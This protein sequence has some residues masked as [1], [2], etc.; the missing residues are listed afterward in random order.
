MEEKDMTATDIMMSIDEVVESDV[1]I[2]HIA[3]TSDGADSARVGTDPDGDKADP[4]SRF[5]GDLPTDGAGE[6]VSEGGDVPAPDFW[7]DFDAAATVDSADTPDPVSRF[8]GETEPLT[9]GEAPSVPDPVTE[10]EREVVTVREEKVAVE[11]ITVTDSTPAPVSTS[12]PATG[13]VPVSETA[14]APAPVAAS[15]PETEGVPVTEAAPAPAPEAIA[16]P[17]SESPTAAPAPAPEA[18]ATPASESPTAKRDDGYVI[19][20]TP[21]SSEK[22]ILYIGG[23]TAC[24]IAV[25]VDPVPAPTAT[26]A[27]TV[28]YSA[29]AGAAASAVGAGTYSGDG[30]PAP[31]STP[32][33]GGAP[34]RRPTFGGMRAADPADGPYTAHTKADRHAVT[35][36]ERVDSLV[37]TVKR[38][39]IPSADMPLATGAT[40]EIEESHELLHHATEGERTPYVM[41][42]RG[43]YYNVTP[44]YPDP[45]DEARPTKKELK[46]R[47]KQAKA[48]EER[49]LLEFE[50]LSKK[51][52]K[53]TARTREEREIEEME[54][55]TEAHR[56]AKRDDE[57]GVGTREISGA[58]VTTA[59]AAAAAISPTEKTA[60][61]EV[62]PTPVF[63]KSELAKT[64]KRQCKN[65]LALVE[66]RMRDEIR[67]LEMDTRTGDISF[68]AKIESGR[69]KRARGKRRGELMSAKERLKA[70]KKFE[71][72]DNNR[73]Y[74]LVLTDMDRVR[75]PRKT[76]RDEMRALR[77]RL[78]ELLR[79]RD[80]LNIELV[81]LYS[82]SSGGKGGLADGRYNAEMKGRKRAFK[83][84][85][86]AYRKY[87]NMQISLADKEK[88]YPLMDERTELYGDLARIAYMLGKERARGAAK[89]QLKRERRG[90]KR[91]LK[92]NRRAIENYEK[93]AL[94][95]ASSRRE[96]KRAGIIGWVVLGIVAV[97][98]VLAVV[99]WADIYE[100]FNTT[101]LP[102]LQE[103]FSMIMQAV[104]SGGGASTPEA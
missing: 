101:A 89:R 26:P 92:E 6:S 54:S 42:Q 86:P 32:V 24:E 63:K 2:S 96:Q 36:M 50:R 40:R 49:E 95:V 16:A 81:D 12:V 13:G 62:T 83:Q 67:R 103:W 74:N 72:A 59:S 48:E 78:I 71:N 68:S 25:A 76:S 4:V 17:A 14:P 29:T 88:I 11:A 51:S 100:W 79:K 56:L 35:E 93:K 70:A 77:E 98:A 33:S 44:K 3:E 55:A 94:R 1:P 52:G 8:D 65:D 7:A 58:A 20:V 60:E 19:T 34:V 39:D 80:E 57:R 43:G 23:V 85:L 69:D 75:L 66:H 47:K 5:G 9:E 27:S 28:A 15:L 64:K 37:S 104:T 73:Y 31:A 21:D 18:I 22:D 53:M 45:T 97:A 102:K 41:V 46:W 61:E 90:I 30:A 87:E 82:L 91:K 38:E 99:F 84:Q 10:A